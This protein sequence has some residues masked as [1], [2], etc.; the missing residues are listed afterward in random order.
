MG[1]LIR[2]TITFFAGGAALWVSAATAGDQPAQ[3]GYVQYLNAPSDC[4]LLLRNNRIEEVG[5]GMSLEENDVLWIGGMPC[6]DDLNK[7]EKDI[8]II[9]QLANGK[10]ELTCI[11]SPF[12]LKGKKPL[13]QLSNFWA[14]AKDIIS[15]LTPLH[16]KKYQMI[17]RGG[18]STS[19]SRRALPLYMPLIARAGGRVMAGRPDLYLAWVGGY[20]PYNLQL[21]AENDVDATTKRDGL[22]ESRVILTRL[23]LRPGSYE[24]MITDGRGR[25]LTRR[26][27]AVAPDEL[28]VPQH[29]AFFIPRDNNPLLRLHETAY[30]SWLSDQDRGLWMLEAYQRV[31]DIASEFY[32]AELIRLELESEL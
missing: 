19:K 30:A 20:P 32:P 13:N 18:G 31:A 17:V 23:D 7:K 26:F 24:L 25:V 14:W 15:L 12:E 8:K 27:K 22:Q 29:E 3:V 4:Y 6:D 21:A 11:N 5:L 9:L 2:W 1:Q 16:A 10:A 28:P